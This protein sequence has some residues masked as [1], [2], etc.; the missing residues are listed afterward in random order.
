[1]A[2]KELSE[3]EYNLWNKKFTEAATSIKNRESRLEDINA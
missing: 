1:M 2:K 3:E